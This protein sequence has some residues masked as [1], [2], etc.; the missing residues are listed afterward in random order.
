LSGGHRSHS[1]EAYVEGVMDEGN[2]RK[3]CQ[4]FKEG[5]KNFRKE[6]RSCHPSLDTDDLKEK[7]KAG[8]LENK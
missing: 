5:G 1:V 4:F 6:E 3:L 8:I 7:V 2:L